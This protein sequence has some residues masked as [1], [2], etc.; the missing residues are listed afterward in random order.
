MQSNVAAEVTR[1]K[2]G[3]RAKPAPLPRLLHHSAAVDCMDT[4]ENTG[5]E[6]EMP[7]ACRRLPRIRRHHVT[8][9]SQPAMQG[10]PVRDVHYADAIPWMKSRGRIAGACAV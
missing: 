10:Q 8:M 2:R 4:G 3:E 1:L 6:P 9:S 5:R 7:V